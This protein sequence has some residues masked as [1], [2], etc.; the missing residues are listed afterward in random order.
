MKTTD[1]YWEQGAEVISFEI[2]GLPEA[3]LV[4]LFRDLPEPSL[5]QWLQYY[6]AREEY[7]VCKVIKE[8]LDRRKDE[9]QSKAA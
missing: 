2:A 8:Q 9:Q 3:E 6:I 1:E 4:D 5:K 7:R